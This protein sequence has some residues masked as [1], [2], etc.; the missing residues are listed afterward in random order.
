MN[1][2]RLRTLGFCTVLALMLM[3][4]ACGINT[5]SPVNQTEHQ[6]TM[7]K[8][9]INSALRDHEKELLAVSG[10]VGIYVGLLPDD[11]TLCLKVMVVKKTDKLKRMIPKLIEGYPVIIEETGAIH[12]LM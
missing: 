12:P 9:D 2:E 5:R 10:V 8:K 4:T 11:K 3:P 7:D 1:L 6:G